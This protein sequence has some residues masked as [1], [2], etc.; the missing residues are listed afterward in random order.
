MA[1]EGQLCS[2]FCIR[3]LYS[4][5]SCSVYANGQ[6]RLCSVYVFKTRDPEDVRVVRN[7]DG[8]AVTGTGLHIAYTFWPLYPAYPLSTDLPGPFNTRVRANQSQFKRK[9]VFNTIFN[10]AAVKAIQ[11]GIGNSN[12]HLRPATF[13]INVAETGIE[14]TFDMCISFFVHIE[15][16]VTWYHHPKDSSKHFRSRKFI[17]KE[18]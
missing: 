13:Y 7:S 10:L 6:A 1:Q 4:C 2:I 8:M 5:G 15:F 18:K 3:Y 14:A 17:W 9:L 11:T 16:R 12:G